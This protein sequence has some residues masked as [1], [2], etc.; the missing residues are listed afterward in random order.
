MYGRGERVL[1]KSWR[2]PFAKPKAC[3]PRPDPSRATSPCGMG[4]GVGTGK[5]ACLAPNAM[6]PAL[7]PDRRIDTAAPTTEFDARGRLDIRVEVHDSLGPGLKAT[8]RV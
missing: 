3:P 5:G 8:R 4:G 6:T 7:A 2:T 1:G